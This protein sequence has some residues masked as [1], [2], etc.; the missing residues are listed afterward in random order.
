MIIITTYITTCVFLQANVKIYGTIERGMPYFMF[1]S[2]GFYL[3]QIHLK[4]FIFV[5]TLCKKSMTQS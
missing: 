4:R 1:K 2:I 3:S 5:V